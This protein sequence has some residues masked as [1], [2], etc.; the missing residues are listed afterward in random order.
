MLDNSKTTTCNSVANPMAAMVRSALLTAAATVPLM[1]ATLPASAQLAFSANCTIN[2]AIAVVAPNDAILF[3]KHPVPHPNGTA[4]IFSII[5]L[6]NDVIPAG[7]NS[8]VI[9]APAANDTYCFQARDDATILQVGAQP[10]RNPG[11]LTACQ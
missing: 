8:C 3:S 7:S 4:T 11:G 2:Q 6:N 5:G 1:A 9:A 10:I